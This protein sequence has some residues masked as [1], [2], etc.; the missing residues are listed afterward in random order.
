M[1]DTGF[2]K[3]QKVTD[4][5][6]LLYP[7]YTK[8][9]INLKADFTTLQEPAASDPPALGD[10]VSIATDHVWASGKGPLPI[11]INPDTLEAPGES[12]GEIGTQ[13]IVWRPSILVL[14]DSKETLEM[15]LNWLNE[16]LV[17]FVNDGCPGGQ[18][19]QFGCDCY[20]A[21]V[22]KN[23]FV[24]GTTLSGQKGYT[25]TIR[26]MCK[27]FYSGAFVPRTS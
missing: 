10:S 3:V 27:Y 7:G 16:E 2:Y 8:A 21:K 17:V 9:W 25:M 1:A 5:D 18:I 12:S 23:T 22:E 11:L 15:V 26:S 20:P 24:S 6:L 4:T 14:G 13:R 19:L